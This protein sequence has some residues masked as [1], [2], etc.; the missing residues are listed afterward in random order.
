MRTTMTKG[1]KPGLNLRTLFALAAALGSPAASRAAWVKVRELNVKPQVNG[2]VFGLLPSWARSS[3]DARDALHEGDELRRP[4]RACRLTSQSFSGLR[5]LGAWQKTLLD[6]QGQKIRNEG[7]LWSSPQLDWDP[8]LARKLSL[9]QLPKSAT[10]WAPELV[11]VPNTKEDRL[12]LA[13]LVDMIPE[14]EDEALEF[15]WFIRRN[16]TEMRRVSNSVNEGMAMLF[17]R[18]PALSPLGEVTLSQ[19]SPQG[20]LANP[21]FQVVSALT[22]QAQ[23]DGGRFQYDPSDPRFDQV[24]SYYFLDQALQWYQRRFGTAISFPLTAKVQIGTKSNS[25]FYYHGQLRIGSGDDVKYHN[26]PRDPSIVMHEAGHAFIDQVAHLPPDGEGGALNEAFA[27]Y[28]AATYLGLPFIGQSAVIGSPFLRNL[29][30]D[31]KA[32][33]KLSDGLYQA[34]LVI[35]GTLWEFR[36]QLGADAADPRAYQILARLGP[37]STIGD[38]SKLAIEAAGAVLPADQQH[39]VHGILEN[40]GWAL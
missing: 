26:M 21:Q 14:S 23:A 7:S 12:E 13:W 30:N 24:Q 20:T 38:F 36:K 34:S 16:Q 27:D 10:Q 40:R 9:P 33:P 3:E 28:L 4:A 39:I 11:L 32:P 15:L 6:E 31:L 18:G 17:P 8:S 19:V 35:S 25:A 2:N 29:D 22:L 37:A 1:W 5:V